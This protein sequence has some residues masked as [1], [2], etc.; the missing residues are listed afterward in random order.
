MFLLNRH[1]YAK[2][3]AI[4]EDKHFGIAEIVRQELNLNSIPSSSELFN[5]TGNDFVPPSEEATR[6]TQLQSQ[7]QLREMQ[8]RVVEYVK[9]RVLLLERNI[10]AEEYLKQ[11]P[12][13]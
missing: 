5:S 4:A 1:G 2:W 8:R 11:N 3:Q 7:L 10:N 13:S 6:E 9:R 12:V